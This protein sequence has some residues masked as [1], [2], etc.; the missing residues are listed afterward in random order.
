VAVEKE[1]SEY[2]TEPKAKVTMG[3]PINIDPKFDQAVADGMNA[4][5]DVQDMINRKLAEQGL[6]INEVGC[7]LYDPKTG[8]ITISKSPYLGP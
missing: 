3:P 5:F 2:M 4:M 6:T 1:R 8:K 7:V